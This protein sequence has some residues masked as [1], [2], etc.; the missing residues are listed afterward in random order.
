MEAIELVENE[1]HKRNFNNTM[2]QFAAYY[3]VLGL[4]LGRACLI[5]T[6]SKDGDF[7]FDDKSRISGINPM[8]LALRGRLR[9]S[10]EARIYLDEN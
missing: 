2:M 10:I 5:K 8:T 1:F 9:S 7:Y 4:V 3:L 6:Y